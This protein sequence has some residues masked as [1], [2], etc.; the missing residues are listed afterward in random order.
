MPNEVTW[1]VRA[2]VQR[3]GPFWAEEGWEGLMDEAAWARFGE[4]GRGERR[5]RGVMLPP[6]HPYAPPPSSPHLFSL[7][8]PSSP[9]L[10]P[11]HSHLHHHLYVLSSSS[12]PTAVRSPRPACQAPSIL[13]PLRLLSACPLTRR[14]KS[15][16]LPR[17]RF[18]SCK[19]W[20]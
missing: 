5:G 10:I 6:L 11:T 9:S 4:E 8:P 13:S 20:L 7:P 14:Q 17:L 2:W 16:F 1:I 3:E 12:I 15:L 18:F 19:M